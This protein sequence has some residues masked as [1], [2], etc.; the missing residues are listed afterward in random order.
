LFQNG[1]LTVNDGVD[2]R[3][4]EANMLDHDPFLLSISIWWHFR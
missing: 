4:C 2:F 3:H 1:Y